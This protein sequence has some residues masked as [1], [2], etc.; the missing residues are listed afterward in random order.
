MS[1]GQVEARPPSIVIEVE[2]MSFEWLWPQL[3]KGFIQS[4]PTQWIYCVHSF[5]LF[6]RRQTTYPVPPFRASV[7]RHFPPVPE[8]NRDSVSLRKE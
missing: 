4:A 7:A 1:R 2:M 5:P 3:V 6:S 8:H